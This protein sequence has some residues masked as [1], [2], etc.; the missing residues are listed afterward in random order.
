MKKVNFHTISIKNF[1][2]VGETPI[3]IN[4]K[5]GLNLITGNNTDN[6]T[7]NGVGK[8]SIIEAIFW[9]L[10]G[11]TIR[12]IKNDKI[13]H[14]QSKKSCEVQLNFDI[15]DF[16]NNTENFTIKRYLGPS[17]IEIWNEDKNITLS[18]IPAND[19]YIK[20]LIGATEELFNNSVIM[21]ANNTL[22]F[23]AQ[24]KIDKRKFIEGVL[25]LSIF[26][27]MLLKTRGDYNDLK[28]ENDILSN[29]FIGEQKNLEIFE[30]QILK[31]KQQKQEKIENF[32][33]SIKNTDLEIK[34]LKTTNIDLLK[35]K[36]EIEKNENKIKELEN[37]LENINKKLIDFGSKS[38][39][40][41]IKIEQSQKSK[42]DLLKKKEICPVCNR[43]Y[44]EEETILIGERVEN[45]DDQIS[46]LIKEKNNIDLEIQNKNQKKDEVKQFTLQIKE[47]NKELNETKQKETLKEEK[48]KNLQNKIEEYKEHIKKIEN[49][50][51][52]FEE[53]IKKIN[54]KIKKTEKD[55]K[56]VKNNLS[57]L[58][59]VKF[60]LSEEGV[61]TYIVKKLLD[62]LNN[63]LNFYLKRLDAPCSCT[64][65]EQFEET[66]LNLN[67]KECSYFNFSG[68][69]RKR[70]D[71]SVLFMFQDILR[72]YSGTSYSLNMYD[73]LFDSA[74]DE[75]GTDK[76]IEILKERV[77]S[78]NESVYIVSHNKASLKNTFDEIIFLEK[79]KGKTLLVS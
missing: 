9:C 62:L 40:L 46:I 3:E 59:N 45:I 13:I 54:D 8:S 61:K 48:I 4:F 17:K 74:I 18:T 33:K 22:P 11:N 41:K 50:K 26:N 2:S 56:K 39:E 31:Q 71:I 38:T 30:K 12:D 27:D 53:E 76:V 77:E 37:L 44:S 36:E 6:Q 29:S 23:M 63:K 65:D 75:A 79:T 15:I 72:F 16:K 58:D 7:R 25:N 64:F 57:I 66:I 60:V 1:L 49:E 73:E 51:S 67:G 10:F 5:R 35:I 14:N 78:Y 28:K 52:D 43:K 21:T 24:K 42:N 68:G 70:I 19:E 34:N 69:E 47:K 20:N 55:L 32:K